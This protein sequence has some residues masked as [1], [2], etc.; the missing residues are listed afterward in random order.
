MSYFKMIVYPSPSQVMSR[1][2][3]GMEASQVVLK[4]GNPLA[5]VV[6]KGVSLVPILHL[7]LKVRDKGSLELG[8]YT[9]LPSSRISLTVEVMFGDGLFELAKWSATCCFKPFF[10]CTNILMKIN[11][12]C[13]V[14][15]NLS[16]DTKNACFLPPCISV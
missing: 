15:E 2:W 3:C 9:P 10:P 16:N 6:T 1:W 14:Y 11:C 4:C 13:S 12:Y 8:L 5:P 7:G